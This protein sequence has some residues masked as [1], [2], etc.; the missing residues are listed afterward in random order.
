[1]TICSEHALVVEASARPNWV[2]LP[3]TNGMATIHN[4]STE[5]KVSG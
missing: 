2:R 3:I 1:M 5:V 4:S